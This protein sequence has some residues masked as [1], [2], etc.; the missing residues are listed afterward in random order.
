METTESRAQRAVQGI[1]LHTDLKY[2]ICNL[3]GRSSFSYASGPINYCWSDLAG[4]TITVQS[5]ITRTV[6]APSAVVLVGTDALGFTTT[7]TVTDLS[8]ARQP[9]I[10]VAYASEDLTLFSTS[11]TPIQTSSITPVTTTPS[12]TPETGLS[13]GAKVGIGVGVGVGIAILAMFM[14]GCLVLRRRKKRSMTQPASSDATWDKAELSGES[15]EVPELESDINGVQ[16]LNDDFIKPELDNSI[17][18]ELEGDWRGWEA[19][20]TTNSEALDVA[21]Q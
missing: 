13:I 17:R 16:E 3:R 11:L 21:K 14:L 2:A 5:S 7:S 8:Q 12:P 9:A 19:P 15:K 20:L 4:L 10:T 1:Q 6:R 18:A